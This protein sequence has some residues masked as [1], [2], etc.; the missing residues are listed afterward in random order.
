VR[1]TDDE[2]SAIVRLADREGLDVADLLRIAA[3]DFAEAGGD[4]LPGVLLLKNR[5][6]VSS[7]KSPDAPGSSNSARRPQ[8]RA[9][10]SAHLTEAS[11]ALR[12]QEQ[13]A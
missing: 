10:V 2:H 3:L 13:D 5:L 4:E 6:R 1:L 11:G 8:E 7:A 12:S 9:G